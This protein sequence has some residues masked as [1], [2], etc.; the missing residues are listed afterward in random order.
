MLVGEGVE[1]G[2]SGI[3]IH[4]DMNG[5]YIQDHEKLFRLRPFP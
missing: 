4:V 3:R 2:W 1:T 5:A